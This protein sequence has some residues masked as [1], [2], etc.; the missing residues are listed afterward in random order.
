MANA[1]HARQQVGRDFASLG[2]VRLPNGNLVMGWTSRELATLRT[3]AVLATSSDG[4]VSWSRPKAVRAGGG[5]QLFVGMTAE[6]SDGVLVVVSDNE[7]LSGVI[8]NATQLGVA[9]QTLDAP[10]M[11]D[12]VVAV[13]G[14]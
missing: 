12:W 13:G 9:T 5:G 8:D 7:A 14:L 11:D 1:S 2:L 10:A 3:Q 6:N 4:G